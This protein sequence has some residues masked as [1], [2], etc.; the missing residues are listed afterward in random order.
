VRKLTAKRIK[1]AESIKPNGEEISFSKKKIFCQ[2]KSLWLEN[3]KEFFICHKNT[4]EVFRFL[5]LCSFFFE[6]NI[7]FMKSIVSQKFIFSPK[8]EIFEIVSSHQ[9]DDSWYYFT[10][11]CNGF[12][13]L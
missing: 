5:F 11:R 13:Q 2:Q 4:K 7:L 10:K 9:A 3:L 12:R 8:D 6:I 1:N